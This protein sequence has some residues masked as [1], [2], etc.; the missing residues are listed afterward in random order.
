MA[1]HTAPDKPRSVLFACNENSIRSPMAEALAKAYFKRRIFVAS[2]G[3]IAGH[4]DPFAVEAMR[5]I[6]IDISGH[7][8]RSFN[9]VEER[10]FSLIISLTPEAQHHSVELTRHSDAQVEY[11]PSFDPTIIEG[12]RETRL[13]AYIQVRDTLRKRIIERFNF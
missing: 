1:P 3:V 12:S 5:L 13:N 7:Q 6:G 11:W 2:T 4:L 8:P 9:D 10:E